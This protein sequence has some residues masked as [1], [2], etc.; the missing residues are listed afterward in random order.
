MLVL[1]VELCM[2]LDLTNSGI[3]YELG[4]SLTHSWKLI[5]DHMIS[6]KFIAQRINAEMDCDADGGPSGIDANG[7]RRMLACKS[8]KES[9]TDLCAAIATTSRKLCTEYVDPLSIEAILVN[10][11]KPLNKGEGEVRPIGVG[12]VLRRIIGKWV[13]KVTKPDVIDASGSLQVCAGHKS[14]SEAAIHAIVIYLTLMK[15]ML[16]CLSMPPTLLML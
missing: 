11:L 5:L 3:I 4:L 14:G 6:H 1:K 12:E 8:F 9:G 10:R 2:V 15:Q 13:M 7:F 16:F